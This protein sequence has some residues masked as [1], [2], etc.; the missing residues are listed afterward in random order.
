MAEIVRALWQ[1]QRLN[2]ATLLPIARLSLLK[3]D[4]Y[5]GTVHPSI[6]SAL[7][8]GYFDEE[9]S[10]DE[11]QYFNEEGVP[12]EEAAKLLSLEGLE[13]GIRA[14]DSA[15]LGSWGQSE[16][17]L[18]SFRLDNGDKTMSQLVGTEYTLN[19]SA[20]AYL[21]FPGLDILDAL[22]KHQGTIRRWVLRKDS[23]LVE[24]ETK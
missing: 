2:R 5:Y 18:I 3:G 1:T 13:E 12:L 4:R 24:F 22:R 20:A 7:S 14:F 17:V 11:E 8:G 16:R 9:V 23:L 21:T 19:Q 6:G 10:F 15:V